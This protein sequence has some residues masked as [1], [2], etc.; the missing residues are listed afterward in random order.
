MLEESWS[1]AGEQVHRA[2]RDCA[3]SMMGELPCLGSLRDRCQEGISHVERFG[4][5][6][7]AGGGSEGGG[8]ESLSPIPGK[9]SRRWV[10]LESSV[11]GLKNL[12]SG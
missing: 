8:D 2:L 4:G 11:S 6:D 1:W 12:H 5:N 3:P 9:E 7:C 10:D